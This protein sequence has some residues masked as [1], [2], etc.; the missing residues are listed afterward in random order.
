MMDKKKRKEMEELIY[1]FFD[2]YDPTGRNTAYYR[3][4]FKDMNDAQFDKYFKD[5]FNDRSPYLTATM[6]D[7]ENPI[8][9]ENIEKAAKFLQVPL[10]ERVVLP[11]ASPDPNKP[12]ITKH[13]CMVGYLNMKRL[14]QINFKK[15]GLSTD[16]SE[17]NM[18]TGQVVGHDKNSRNSDAETTAL[19]TV[20][21]K[22]SLKEFM[23]ARADDMIMKKEMNQ[24]ILKDGYVALADLT[25]DI[26][27]KT[28]LNSAAVYFLGAGLMNDLVSKD[29]VLPKTLK[30]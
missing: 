23:S 1:G 19:I 18:V 24:K 20:G 9:I 5:L 21:A 4:K 17:R 13:E 26:T 12:I 30:D 25:D 10:F 2:L 6:I 3:N 15:L 14:Q 27:N 16:T 22:E 28:T 7:Y 11:Y 8:K 29:Y